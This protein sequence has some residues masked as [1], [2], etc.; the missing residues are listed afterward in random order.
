MK[1]LTRVSPRHVKDPPPSMFL[2]GDA[3]LQAGR[4]LGIF[5]WFGFTFPYFLDG[6]MR[7]SPPYHPW[8]PQKA[9]GPFFVFRVGHLPPGVFLERLKAHAWA[10]PAFGQGFF[11]FPW[12]PSPFRVNGPPSNDR[13]RAERPPAPIPVGRF[14]CFFL[15]RPSPPPGTGSLVPFGQFHPPHPPR[16]F[17]V[18]RIGFFSLQDL[19]QGSFFLFTGRRRF[20]LTGEAGG[21]FL[22]LRT[23]P[24][25]PRYH[26][27]TS[28]VGGSSDGSLCH[29]SFP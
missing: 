2:S 15:I 17:N 3:L 24:T 29:L 7:A 13:G 28:R 16:F 21:V 8:F 9:G 4:N 11:V 26:H 22:P 27:I 18:Q 14:N 1:L 12:T 25:L 10:L 5:G 20:P 6:D 19:Y 23:N